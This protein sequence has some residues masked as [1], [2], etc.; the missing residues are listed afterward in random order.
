MSAAEKLEQLRARLEKRFGDAILPQ[1]GTG[2]DA[3]EEGAF[4]TGVGAIDGL[5]PGGVPRRALSLW[6]GEGTTGRTAAVRRVVEQACAAGARVALVDATMTLDAAAWCGGE[7]GGPEARLWVARPPSAS[8]AEEGAWVA[9]SLLRS[10]AFDLVVLDGP[11]PGPVEA[12]RL[13]ALA[14]ETGAALL[15]SSAREGAGWR[16][17]LKLEFGARGE[18][19]GS[20]LRSGG[21]FRRRAAVRAAKAPGARAGEREVELVHEPSHRLHPGPRAADRRAAAW[22]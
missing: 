10:G 7:E 15:V 9:E 2:V 13:R 3:P 22:T 6:T 12:H 5:L 17:D 1:P 8:L 18:S 11:V 4:R 21:R 20:G 16:A 19:A 14:R